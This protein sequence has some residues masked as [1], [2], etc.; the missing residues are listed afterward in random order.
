MHL[1]PA[2]G[3]S[4]ARSGPIHEGDGGGMGC[5]SHTLHP[6]KPLYGCAVSIDVSMRGIGTAA[7]I[8][9]RIREADSFYEVRRAS[10]YASEG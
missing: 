5:W 3:R 7:M 9:M 6:A 8:N 1:R 4:L 10:G 2:V